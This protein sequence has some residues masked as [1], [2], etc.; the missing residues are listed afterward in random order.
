MLIS[1]AQGRCIAGP[2]GGG[3]VP[4]GGAPTSACSETRL[5]HTDIRLLGRWD[6]HSTSPQQLQR[7]LLLPRGVIRDDKLFG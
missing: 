1:S 6:R 7:Q 4:G 5:W 3:C 2:G